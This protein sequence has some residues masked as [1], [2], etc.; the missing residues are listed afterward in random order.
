MKFELIFELAEVK[1]MEMTEGA[2]MRMIMRGFEGLGGCQ[3][4][5]KIEVKKLEE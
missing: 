2:V 1:D 5:R 4:I 3:N